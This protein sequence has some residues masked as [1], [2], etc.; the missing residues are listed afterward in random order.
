MPL[1]ALRKIPVKTKGSIKATTQIIAFPLN[2][3]HIIPMD[4]LIP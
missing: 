4:D 3:R 2:Q 1:V